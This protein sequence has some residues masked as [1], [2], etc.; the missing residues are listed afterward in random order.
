MPEERTVV[1]DLGVMSG[2]VSILLFPIAFVAVAVLDKV[3]DHFC[4]PALIGSTYGGCHLTRPL[5]VLTGVTLILL[6]PACWLVGW[7]LPRRFPRTRGVLFGVAPAVLL[8]AIILIAV[9]VLLA[10]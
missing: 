1:S 5:L 4:G 8:A 10:W 7:A 3:D 9:A 2:L 6:V